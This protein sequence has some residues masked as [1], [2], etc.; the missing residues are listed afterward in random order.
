MQAAVRSSG[1]LLDTPVPI[2]YKLI[3]LKVR[4][5]AASNCCYQTTGSISGIA[6]NPVLFPVNCAK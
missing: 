4:R 3:L 1:L 6:A 5:K 2:E